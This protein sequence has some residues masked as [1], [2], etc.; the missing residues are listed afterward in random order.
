[1]NEIDPTTFSE[2]TQALLLVFG[3]L[4]AGGGGYFFGRKQRV[5]IEPNPIEVAP[6]EL[7]RLKTDWD[8]RHEELRKDLNNHIK[9]TRESFKT[10][11]LRLRADEKELGEVK[12]QI[13]HINQGLVRIENKLDRLIERATHGPQ[14]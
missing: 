12:G 10:V 13:L 1:M 4:F 2:S 9:A 6:S 11:E 5:R 3:I 7:T 14:P 8:K